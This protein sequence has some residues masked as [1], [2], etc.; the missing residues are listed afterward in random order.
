MIKTKYLLSRVLTKI[1]KEK[2]MLIAMSVW[3]RYF[4]LH[5]T[6]L[7]F[8]KAPINVLEL[9]Y[10]ASFI[11]LVCEYQWVPEASW[12]RKILQPWWTW[13]RQGT[14]WWSWIIPRWLQPW[15]NKRPCCCTINWRPWAVPNTRWQVAKLREHFRLSLSIDTIFMSVRPVRPLN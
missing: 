10:L 15:W 5:I 6:S 8:P 14:R 12:R 1:L 11:V 9:T 7:P 13:Q 2:K 4:S 3:R